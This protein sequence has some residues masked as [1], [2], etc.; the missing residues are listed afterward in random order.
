[1]SLIDNIRN[2]FNYNEIPNEPNF[3]AVLFGENAMYLENIKTIVKYDKEQ[4]VLSLKDGGLDILGSELFIK[5]YC[6]GDLVVCGKIKK[7][8]K[9]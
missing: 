5:K 2:C 1:M 6:G 3:R 4:I 8:E 7:I 9:I